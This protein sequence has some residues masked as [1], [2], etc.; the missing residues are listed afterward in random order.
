MANH[1]FI[2][3]YPSCSRR[4][5]IY[6]DGKEAATLDEDVVKKKMLMMKKKKKKKL[7]NK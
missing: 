6:G 3:H 1:T 4:L 2:H 7:L 5:E